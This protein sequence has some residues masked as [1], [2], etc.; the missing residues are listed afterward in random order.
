MSSDRSISLLSGGLLTVGA[1]VAAVAEAH[2]VLVVCSVLL[3]YGGAAQLVQGC[4]EETV[5]G[6]ADPLPGQEQQSGRADRRADHQHQY[7]GGPAGPE[8]FLAAND[9]GKAHRRGRWAFPAW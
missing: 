8:D 3:G 9:A 6:D 4:G 1:L 7:P 5:V 2:T